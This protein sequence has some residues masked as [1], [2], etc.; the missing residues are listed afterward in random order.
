M[1]DGRFVNS[2]RDETRSRITMHL[3]PG[4]IRGAAAL[5]AVGLVVGGAAFAGTAHRTATV[6]Q[7]AIATPAK[8]NDYGWNQQGVNAAK[9]AAASAHAKLTPGHEHRVRQDRRRA[10][11]AGPGRREPDHRPRER[12]RHDRQAH[13]PAV[14]GSGHHL[15]HPDEPRPRARSRTSRP[16]ARRARTWPACWRPR[17]TKTGTVGIVI[18]AADTNWYKMSGGFAAGVRSVVEEDQDPVHDDRP[19]LLRRRRRRQAASRRA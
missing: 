2:Q 1:P 8:A 7:V 11:P 17:T 19:G 9:A 4:P 16:R 15:R 5:V 6:T 14:Q 12:L 18:S 3:R 10:P 13:R